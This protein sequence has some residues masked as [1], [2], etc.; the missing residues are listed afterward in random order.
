MIFKQ[1]TLDVLWF[2]LSFMSFMFS[3]KPVNY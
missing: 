2:T 1:I 3:M